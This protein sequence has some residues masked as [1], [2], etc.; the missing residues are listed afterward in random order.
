ML[1]F[2]SRFLGIREMLHSSTS[3]LDHVDASGAESLDA[4]V[5]VHHAF[6]LGHIQ[7]DVQ[8]DVAAGPARPHAGQGREERDQPAGIHHWK[9]RG[10]SGEPSVSTETLGPIL[11]Y[12][13]ARAPAGAFRSLSGGKGRRYLQWTTTGPPSGGV[14]ALTRRRKASSPVAW[15]GTPC[16]GQEVKWN[17]H[18]SCLAG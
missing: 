11:Q 2:F 6:A 13:E 10:L 3:S 1:R 17:W 14:E 9:R 12:N 18:T 15:Y 8:H 5:D 4:V 16:S 7:H